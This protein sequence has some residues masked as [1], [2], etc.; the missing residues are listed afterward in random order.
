MKIRFLDK[1]AAVG[2]LLAASSCPACL[3]LL[4]AAGSA[5]GLGFLRPYQGVMM[6]VFQALVLLAFIGAIVSFLNHRKI[7]PLLLNSVGA[8]LIFF[9][10]YIKF[11]AVLIYAGLFL[12]LAGAVLNFLAEKKCNRCKTP[13]ISKGIILKS[14][15]K[16]P[17]CGYIKE[18]SM[19][20]DS[21]QHFYECSNCRKILHPKNGDCCVFCSYGSSKCPPKQKI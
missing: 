16:C 9:A 8:F 7:T 14:K 6:Y 3:P 20:A 21:C 18:E 19:P 11:I 10:F 2:A 13:F 1:I 5:A 17:F 4:A 15:I 12:L